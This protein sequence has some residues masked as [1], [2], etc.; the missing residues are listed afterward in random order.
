MKKLHVLLAVDESHAALH[1]CRLVASYTGDPTA[2]SITLLSVQAPPLMLASN[3][4]VHHAALEAALYEQ[5]NAV[6]EKP[7]QVLT[8]AGLSAKTMVRIGLASATILDTAIECD[9]GLI[10]LGRGRTGVLGGYALGSVA[11]RVASASECPVVL[12]RPEARLPTALGQRT[13]T[14]VAVDGSPQSVRAVE[15]LVL[16]APLLGKLHVDLVHFRPG[17]PLALAILPPHDDVLREWSGRESETALSTGLKLLTEAGIS[18]QVHWRT[19]APAA[20]IPAFASDQGSDL[21]VMGSRGMGAVHH[22]LLGSVALQTALGSD[23]PV[24]LMR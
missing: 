16:C 3:A 4:G 20:G 7:R 11:L 2:L 1:A 13:S 18:H 22:L 12:V 19:G 5:G 24:V 15:R 23:V 21:I 10:V 6:L 9:A 14:T 17:L 8:K